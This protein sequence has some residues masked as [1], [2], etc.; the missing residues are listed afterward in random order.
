ML[1][2]AKRL[3]S[4]F[5][6]FCQEY[7]LQDMQLSQDEWRQVDYLL[8]ITQPFFI[9][10]N[11]VSKSKDITIH[12]VFGIYN[13]L[14]SH[15]EKS[16]RRLYPKKVPWKTVILKALSYAKDKLSEY[17]GATD[18]IDD[19]LYAIGTIMAP[20][21][22]LEFFQTPEWGPKW[23]VRYRKSL[24]KYLMPYEKR[25]S[26]IQPTSHGSPSAAQVS[27]LEMLISKAT[28]VQSQTNATDELRRYI[29]SGK[30]MISRS[31]SLFSLLIIFIGTRLVTPRVFWKDHQDEFPILASLARDVLSTPATGSGVE[32]LFNSARDICHYR[33]GSLKPKTIRDLMMYMCTTQFDVESDQLTFI[34]EYL[35]T[36]EIHAA[37]EKEDAEKKKEEFDLISD[38]EDNTPNTISQHPGSQRPSERT[39]GKRPRKEATPPPH[40]RGVLIQ[41]DNEDDIPLPDNSMHGESSTQRRTSG[42][43]SKRARRDQDIFEYQK[44]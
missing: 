18:T 12:T 36:Q 16:K 30:L 6:E 13:A 4:I 15:I 34:E 2:R 27:D 28:P 11:V 41:L 3:Q 17:Y 5:D 33:R 21:N 40:Q 22:K 8:S 42:R 24:E 37:R 10:T 43:V 44:P 39:P 29:G 19:D 23:H 38:G 9:F 25:Y 35:S 31:L 20:Q 7:N 1:R 32:R 26:D 14:F